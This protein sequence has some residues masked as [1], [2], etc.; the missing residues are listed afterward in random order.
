MELG[1]A[2]SVI[3]EQQWNSLFPDTGALPPYTGQP[4]RGYS[5]HQLEVVGQAMVQVTYEKQSVTLPLVVTAGIHKPALFGKNWL[6]CSY[7]DKME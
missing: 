6:A 2:I 4:L 5:G 3:S 1:A 7:Q